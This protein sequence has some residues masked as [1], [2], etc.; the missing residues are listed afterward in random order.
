MDTILAKLRKKERMNDERGRAPSS[1][2]LFF[3]FS[4]S[5]FKIKQGV[6]F[7]FFFKSFCSEG[8]LE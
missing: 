7:C 1:L 2:F 4:V 5:F 6:K 3:F 8:Y